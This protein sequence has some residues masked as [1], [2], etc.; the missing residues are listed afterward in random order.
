MMSRRRWPIAAILLVLLGAVGAYWLDLIPLREIED[1]DFA[2]RPV[3]VF[4]EDGRSEI[5]Y[6]ARGQQAWWQSE[7]GRHVVWVSKETNWRTVPYAEVAA[8]PEL[9]SERPLYGAIDFGRGRIEPDGKPY[10]FVVDESQGTGGGYDRLIFDLD[11]DLDLT[12][13]PVQ[14]PLQDPPA[15][16]HALHHWGTSVVFAPLNVPFDFGPER[17][18]RPVK[19]LPRLQIDDARPSMFF[20][21]TEARKGQIQIGRRRFQ[22]IVAQS[23]V[24]SGRYDGLGTDLYLATTGFP[25]VGLWQRWWGD[26]CLDSFRL[27]D[28]ELY[29]LSVTPDGDT[30]MVRRYRGEKGILRIEPGGRPITEVSMSGS[31]YSEP[32]LVIVPVGRLPR[33]TGRLRNVAECEL[34]VGDYYPSQMRYRYGR[35]RFWLSN[36][37]H[38]DGERHGMRGIPPVHAVRI[39]KDQPFVLDFSNRPEVLFV[40]PAKDQTFSS[41]EEI[42]VAA[43]L[44]DPVLGTMIRGLNDTSRKVTRTFGAR[45]IEQDLSLDPKVT[46]TDRSGR[47]LAQGT[48]PF[49]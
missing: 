1:G 15:P 40:S 38:S 36:T 23:S 34:P 2:L 29:K 14:E 4:V 35:L 24:V 37:Y 39:R 45:Q 16:S 18:T 28:G 25:R 26:D 13:D 12:N 30:L 9:S 8:Y 32:A 19:M 11:R 43:V 6:L 47:T 7:L 48:M 27:V 33:V 22:A 21:A 31:L 5:Q 46:I 20:V 42:K 10:Y 3:S 41:G 17:G 44:V 49:G